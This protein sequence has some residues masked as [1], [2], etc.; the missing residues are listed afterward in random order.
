MLPSGYGSVLEGIA[1]LF[2]ALGQKV[3]TSGDLTVPIDS[4]GSITIDAAF[5][6]VITLDG[7]RKLALDLQGGIGERD[8]GLLAAHWTDGKVL[9]FGPGIPPRLIIDNLLEESRFARFLRKQEVTC[10]RM[11][12]L[13]LVADWQV[14]AT[15]EQLLA[16]ERINLISWLDEGVTPLPAEWGAFLA[17]FGFSLIEIG[18]GAAAAKAGDAPILSRSTS[19]GCPSSTLARVSPGGSGSPPAGGSPSRSRTRAAFRPRRSPST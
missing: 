15:G 11:A 6:P 14:V 7:G 3:Q 18:P 5:Y 17:R 10:G 2:T 8:R 4:G 9:S 16:G 19:G 12:T 1:A 13:T